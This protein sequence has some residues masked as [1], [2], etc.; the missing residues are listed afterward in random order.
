MPRRPPV[1]S[2]DVERELR[3]ELAEKDKLLATLQNKINKDK[4]QRLIPAP[5]GSAG[6]GV[7]NGG[8][9]LQTEM[10]LDDDR[11]NRLLRIIRRYVQKDVPFFQRYADGWP[12]RDMARVWLSNEQTR[13]RKD[14]EEELA[15]CEDDTDYENEPQPTK[16][17]SKGSRVAKPADEEEDDEE[18][19]NFLELE[20]ASKKKSKSTR[21]AQPSEEEEEEIGSS[22]SPLKSGKAVH[23]EEDE[24]VEPV[25]KSTVKKTPSKK[26]MNI[27]SD[28]EED[29][30]NTLIGSN[31]STK[32]SLKKPKKDNVFPD[33]LLE[34]KPIKKPATQE[35]SEKAPKKPGTKRKAKSEADAGGAT[36]KQKLDSGAAKPK[37]RKV[38]PNADDDD[39]EDE[40]EAEYIPPPPLTWDKLP[41]NCPAALCSDV[42]PDEP[43]NAILSLHNSLRNLLHK[44]GE[45]AKGQHWIQLQICNAISLEKRRPA[46]LRRAEQ[47]HWLLPGNADYHQLRIRILAM[48]TPILKLI[49][50]PVALQACPTWDD[51]MLTIN[52]NIAAFSSAKNKSAFPGAVKVKR[53][54]YYGP[55]GEFIIYSCLMRLVAQLQEEHSLE[56]DLFST[57]HKLVTEGE[58]NALFT[59]DND[60]ELASSNYLS[61]DDFIRFILVP[62]TAATLIMEDLHYD[63][64]QDGIFARDNSNDYG[65]LFHPEDDEDETVHTIH[66]QNLTGIKLSERM[67]EGDSAPPRHRKPVK[68]EK[69]DEKVEKKNNKKLVIK[70]A[71]AKSAPAEEI[72]IDDYIPPSTM[73]KGSTGKKTPTTK[74]K[75]AAAKPKPAAKPK[76][77]VPAERKYTTRAKGVHFCSSSK[78]VLS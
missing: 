21:K 29:D 38:K 74:V 58:D 57:I 16:R 28:G 73:R 70:V 47:Q 42:L 46:M 2:H 11:Y 77:P 51:L 39:D 22:K 25:I 59:Y 37:K 12:I 3:A 54:G 15:A 72:T 40:D 5:K 9:T 66:R 33:Y 1:S 23:F 78:P 24:E 34:E 62:F 64:L 31:N 19:T 69:E 43:V 18:D 7:D 61:I 26:V 14:L 30:L 60:D 63:T 17:K 8:Y 75:E 56:D 55:Q 20:P 45:K 36:K 52:Y 35:K 65:Q 48:E 50:D 71:P 67:M 27:E 41:R 10:H 13:R 6:R 44:D 68:V 32:I 53:C 49:Q 76:A 4:R